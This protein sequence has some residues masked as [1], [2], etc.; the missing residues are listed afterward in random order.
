MVELA[1]KLAQD[2]YPEILGQMFIVNAP[3]LFSAIWSAI[4]IFIDKKTQHKIKILGSDYKK[5]LFEHVNI[6]N[7]IFIYIY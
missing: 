3:Y 4:K 7:L 6:N 5:V 1:S 2:N